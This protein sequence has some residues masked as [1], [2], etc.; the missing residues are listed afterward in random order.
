VIA[1]NDG[2]YQAYVKVVLPISENPLKDR[3]DKMTLSR[4]N[5]VE[6]EKLLRELDSKQ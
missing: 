6:G 4:E 5:A 1:L 3:K 2:T